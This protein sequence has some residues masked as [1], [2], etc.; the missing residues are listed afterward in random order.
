MCMSV[1]CKVC[2]LSSEQVI[3]SSGNILVVTFLASHCYA[4][5][6][7]NFNYKFM[8]PASPDIGVMGYSAGSLTFLSLL[9]L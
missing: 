3:L 6:M 4:T 8:L 2:P 9:L 5:V 7:C 1:I